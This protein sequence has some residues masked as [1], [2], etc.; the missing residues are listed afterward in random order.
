MALCRPF[1]EADHMVQVFSQ[2]VDILLLLFQ[3]Q[4]MVFGKRLGTK[5]YFSPPP[6]QTMTMCLGENHSRNY[7]E[8]VDQHLSL[9]VDLHDQITD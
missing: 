3:T 8:L 1:G 2:S 4:L 6:A 9:S 7:L 5:I